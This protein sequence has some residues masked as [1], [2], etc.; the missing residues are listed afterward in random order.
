MASRNKTAK[1][2]SWL[3]MLKALVQNKPLVIIRFDEDDWDGLCNSRRG[4]NEFTV[5]RPHALVYDLKTP[6]ACIL[7]GARDGETEIYFGLVKSKDVVT[8]L[9]RRI[10][11]ASAHEISPSS[12][13]ALLALIDD[14]RIETNFRTRLQS[15]N[16]IVALSPAL[17]AH[18]VE[19][20][21][22]IES[23]QPALR[24]VIDSL[25]A[26]KSYSD[27]AA[28]QE[29]AVA[30]A[31]K[32]FGLSAS[33]TAAQVE[34]VNGGDTA[35]A[36]VSIL[37]D[38]VIEHH[39]RTVP[40]FT[41]TGSGLTGRAVFRK[42]DEVLEVITANKRPL[43]QVFGVD[44][45]YLNAT[46]HN[47]VMVQYKM[48]EADR[49]G[50]STDWLYRPDAQFGKEIA[51]MDKFARSHA[52]GSLEYRINPQVFYLRFVRR[53]E[54]LGHKTINMTIDHYRVLEKDPACRGP[55]GAFRVSY[56]TL[57]GRYLRQE[58]FLDL[59]HGGYIGAYAKTTR[60][61]ATLIDEVLKGNRALVAAVQS[62][63][64]RKS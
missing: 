3:E 25:D 8:T 33:D 46:K 13:A 11:V 17:S 50:K 31:L 43:E 20:L 18:L 62:S 64:V 41:L 49:S 55:K 12:E 15:S 16:S 7:S 39:A 45:I 2:R 37:E 61:L 24:T 14:K 32:T 9:D 26:P 58:G 34:I 42:G 59:I 40:G 36:R 28:L 38:A 48:L 57:G 54:A 29:D 56:E 51:R 23:N 22:M 4:A 6:T 52:P 35:L 53:D 47:V 30:L 27:N 19:K 1:K 44:L 60:D 21:A 5:A 10:K 63:L